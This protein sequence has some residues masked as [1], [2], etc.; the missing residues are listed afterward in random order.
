MARILAF[1]YGAIAYIIFFVTF[2]YAI[3]FVGNMFVPKAIDSGSEGPFAP[4]LIIDALLLGMFAIQHSVMA[5]PGFKKA[6]TKIVPQVVERSTYVLLAS[7]LL[8]LLFWQWRPLLG[9]VWEVR[10]PTIALVLT[11]VF[12]AGWAIVL[13]S[14]FLINHFDLFGLRQV[15]LYK[16]YTY[17]GFRTPV[18]YKIVRHP[19]MLGFIIAFWS[20]PKMTLGHLVFAI[21]TTAYILIAIQIEERDLVSIH[22]EAYEDYRKQVSMLLPLPPKK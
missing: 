14:T 8:D 5:R 13:I 18:I 17:L 15:Y 2:L 10:N 19:I 9:V 16:K 3:G 6:W 7:L 11:V 20:T 12:F 22:G 4:S 21:A 1:L